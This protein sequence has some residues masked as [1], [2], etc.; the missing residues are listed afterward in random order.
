MKIS[1]VNN[2]INFGRN[3][4]PV[5]LKDYKTTLKEG[6]ELVGQTGKSVFIMPSSCLPQTD[7]FNSG[8]GNLSSDISQ[9]YLRYMRD[10]TG[11]NIVEDLPAG[12]IPKG[13]SGFYCA[14][15]SSAF[16]L[17]N[18]QIN[19]E[20]LTTKEFGY[21]LKPNEVKEIASSNTSP[22]KDELV[23]F[24]N[25]MDND[26]AQ[27]RVLKKA[28]SRFEKL[29][30]KNPLKQK[31]EQYKKDNDFW[32]NF[33]R[34]G[35][36]NQEFF[37]FKQ[38]LADEHLRIGKEKLNKEGIKLCGDCL[39]GF[40]EDEVR[41]FPKAFKKDSF[42]GMPEWGLPALNYEEVTKEGSEANKLLKAKVQTFAKRYDMIRFDVA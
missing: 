20:L 10:Y 34:E 39:I 3:L 30:E 37:K 41:A 17:G 5:E 35:E 9:D 14:Y 26:G 33:K 32:L 31:F 1:A 13:K 4:S 12:Q 16:A 2:Q 18:H 8:I 21:I 25:V 29:N 7:S 24:S 22:L 19:P 15:D 38:F 23:N 6:K 42:I 36:E 40:S 27:N 11:F 28:F